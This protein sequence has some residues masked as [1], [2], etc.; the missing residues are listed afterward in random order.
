MDYKKTASGK[1][2]SAK[3]EQGHF[4]KYGLKTNLVSDHKFLSMMIIFL[5][6]KRYNHEEVGNALILAK[7]GSKY[8]YKK[9][10]PFIKVLATDNRRL[11]N[12]LS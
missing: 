7:K 11:A 10:D 3:N 8:L 2:S 5:F 6:E 9:R 12:T 1:E 4:T